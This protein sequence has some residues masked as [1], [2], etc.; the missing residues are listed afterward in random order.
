AERFTRDDPYR[1]FSIRRLD[2][3]DF[4]RRKLLIV[5]ANH[6]LRLRQIY[7]ELHAVKR[8]SGLFKFLRRL[9][10]MDNTTACCH[11]LNVASFQFSFVSVGILVAEVSGQHVG[12]CF[13]AAVRMIRSALRLSRPDMHRTHL[14]E[15]QEWVEIGQAVG[16]EWP[17]NQKTSSFQCGDAFY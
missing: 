11:P 5:R 9:F 6:L 2:G 16:W 1:D 15:Q 3:G 13:E 7:P 12:Y 10:R 14:V 17:M 4:G 8:S